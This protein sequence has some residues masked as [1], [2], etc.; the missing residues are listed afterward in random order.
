[1]ADTD[2]TLERDSGTFTI[3]RLQEL[4]LSHVGVTLNSFMTNWRNPSFLSLDH[5][6]SLRALSCLRYNCCDTAGIQAVFVEPI[7]SNLLAQL[8][9][10]S[11]DEFDE[12][13]N[14]RSLIRDPIPIPFLYDL[15]HS[16]LTTNWGRHSLPSGPLSQEY[17]RIRLPRDR[18]PHRREIEA[19]LFL[20]EDLVSESQ[21][22]KALHL[23]LG[24]GRNQLDEESKR[25]LEHLEDPTRKKKVEIVWE[26]SGWDFCGSLVSMEF[27]KRSKEIKGRRT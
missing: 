5:F 10:L 3:P 22:L 19:A 11:I 18:P 26:D 17:I 21:A 6:P 24:I 13:P 1:M 23:D 14:D 16:H 7:P 8:E 9:F 2:I 4:S 15:D 27:W 20:V 25:R 12:T